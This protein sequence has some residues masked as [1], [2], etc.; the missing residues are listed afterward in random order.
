MVV[1]GEGDGGRA[2]D[3]DGRQDGGIV[4]V[5]GCDWG[6]KDEWVGIR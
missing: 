1:G 4:R 6:L 2:G 3:E 5:D